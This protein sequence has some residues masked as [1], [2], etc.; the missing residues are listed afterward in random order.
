LQPIAL[1]LR[2]GNPTDTVDR[3]FDSQHVNDLRLIAA[4]GFVL[5]LLAFAVALITAVS[6]CLDA[7]PPKNATL[8]SLIVFL[9]Q[10]G[11]VHFLTIFAPVSATFGGI[12]A[13]AYQVGSARLG[14]VDLFACEIDTLTRVVTVIGMISTLLNRDSDNPPQTAA[15]T[16]N[17]SASS[18][19]FSSE[20]NYF[21][22]LDSNAR[23]LQTLEAT[24]VIN[25]TAFYT[26]MKAMR[27]TFRH[28]ADSS[29]SAR[30]HESL[31]NLI[32]MLYLALESGRR[33]TDDL[34]EFEPIHTERTLTTLLAE[35]E[36]Y[37]FLRAQYP[38]PGEVRHDRLILR[39]P[40]YT[41]VVRKLNDL[42][43]YRGQ[44]LRRSA[45][46]R[47]MHAPTYED[48]QWTAALQSLPALNARFE[49]L[50]S[51]FALEGAPTDLGNPPSPTVSPPPA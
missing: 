16:A 48:A 30:R 42:L 12:L 29:S 46:A 1:F 31:K 35:L 13:W 8:A 26:Y 21:P 4:T 50:R 23:D 14:V 15:A 28:I 41:A 2:T 18:D 38:T 27:D 20:E 17:P 47:A 9:A 7:W 22:I 24:V 19:P 34:V 5:T 44:V 36:A 25:I 10:C 32:Y 11:G 6:F 3:L 40:E 49:T 51:Q 43:L 45:R 39:G 37:T 33:A